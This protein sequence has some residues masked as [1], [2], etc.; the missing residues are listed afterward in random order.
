MGRQAR[1]HPTVVA[2]LGLANPAGLLQVIDE[3]MYL[4]CDMSTREGNVKVRESSS[5]P[6]YRLASHRFSL[7]RIF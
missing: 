1:S 7:S 6:S 5:F 3:K 4:E 2:R